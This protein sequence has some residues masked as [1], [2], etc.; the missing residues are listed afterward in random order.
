MNK[1][2]I[3]QDH[4]RCIGCFACEIHCKTNKNLPPGPRLCR[5]IPGKIT[6]VEGKPVQKFTFKTCFHCKDPWCVK[7]C[8]TE[9]IKKREKDG[10]VFIESSLCNGCKECIEACPWKIPQF[11]PTTKKV[12]K[13]D[14]CKDRVDQGLEPACVTK[15]TTHALK[16][17]N[18]L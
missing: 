18:L 11:N 14:Y 6:L 1:Y 8:P 3:S 7:A 4:K 9:A 13:C 15:C 17:V 5:I 10:I 12:V 2:R 16:W